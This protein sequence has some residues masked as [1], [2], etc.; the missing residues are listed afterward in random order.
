MERGFRSRCG[1]TTYKKHMFNKCWGLLGFNVWTRKKKYGTHPVEYPF[2]KVWAVLH[3]IVP[4]TCIPL[5]A[6]YTLNLNRSLNYIWHHFI[7]I[8]CFTLSQ[9]ITPKEEERDCSGYILQP[10]KTLSTQTQETMKFLI[11]LCFT[12]K[13]KSLRFHTNSSKPAK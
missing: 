13:T 7:W 9:I 10:N 1:S 5:K 4:V 12:M 11:F 8:P 2:Q 6:K 3:Y